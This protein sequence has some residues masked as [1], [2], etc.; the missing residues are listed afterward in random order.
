M[1]GLTKPATESHIQMF[2]SIE[3]VGY[4]T[5][6]ISDSGIRFAIL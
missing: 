4:A 3:F 2:R 6:S 1:R 5:H